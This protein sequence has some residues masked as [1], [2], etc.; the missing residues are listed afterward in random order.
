MFK[1]IFVPRV[2]TLSRRDYRTQPGVLTPGTDRKGTRPEGGGRE[3]FSVLECRTRSSTNFCRPCGAGPYCQCVLGLKPQAQSYSP[4]GTKNSIRS[5][6]LSTFSKPHHSVR[7]ESRTTTR[8]RTRTKRL[9]RT[10]TLDPRSRGGTNPL[11]KSIAGSSPIRM[12]FGRLAPVFER[13][14][15]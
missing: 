10:G 8:T 9:V 7:K 2:R 5:K 3:A 13:H 4:F 1:S 12:N 11:A 15:A 6:Y 14:P